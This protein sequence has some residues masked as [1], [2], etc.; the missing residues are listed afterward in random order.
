MDIYF[1]KAYSELSQ[2]IENGVSE[3]YIYEDMNG[4][5]TYSFIKRKIPFTENHY[6][7]T[8]PYGYGGPIIR[9]INGDKKDL[10]NSFEVHFSKY[11]QF[12]NIIAE[13]IRFHPII[14]NYDDFRD[15]Y[16]LKY[17]RKTIGTNLRN[18]NNPELDEFS[19]STKKVVR[20]SYKN[21]ITWD[22]IKKPENL[23]HFISLY[24]ETMERNNADDY[25]YFSKNYFLTM[26]N[27]ISDNVV[28]INLYHNGQ[29]VTSGLYFIYKDLMHA[30]LSA[31]KSEFLDLGTAY[32]LKDIAVKWAKANGYSLVHYGGGT[33][34]DENDPLL[35][36]K[37]RFSKSTD[38]D[39]Y[40]GTKI[41]NT[42]K[43]NDL[44]EKTGTNN[45]SFFPKYRTKKS[46]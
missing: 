14:K 29:C 12:N 26:L 25:Y 23:D 10:I 33:T 42:E 22:I 36:F 27:L 18:S 5:I 2:I 44:V 39:F 20:R 43:Y 30:H 37:K 13:F 21:N 9:A 46:E 35:F 41:H 1:E 19:K 15:V 17:M 7:I 4:K 28:N 45:S 32:V 11:C 40:I 8:T 31:T 3:Y 24:F 34:N 38:F 6:D 16:D